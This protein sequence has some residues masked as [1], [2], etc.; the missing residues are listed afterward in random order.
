MKGKKLTRGLSFSFTGQ[1]LDRLLRLPLNWFQRRSVGDI[2]S[3]FGSL[4]P[5]RD[6]FT[7]GAANFCVDVT[8]VLLSL[9]LMVIYQWQLAALVIGLQGIYVAGCLMIAGRIRE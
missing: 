8:L 6:F 1:L 2:I 4:Q 3:R 9:V 7:Q 5:V